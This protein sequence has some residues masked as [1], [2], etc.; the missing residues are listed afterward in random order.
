[1]MIEPIDHGER[2]RDERRARPC[3]RTVI[4]ARCGS[5][6]AR[7]PWLIGGVSAVTVRLLV[8]GP[9]RRP[10]SCVELRRLRR[11][12]C[13]S[14]ASSAVGLAG[15]EL[16]HDPALVHDEDAVGRARG[17]PRVRGS[18][19]G[20]PCRASRSARICAVHELDRADVEPARR[21][22]GDEQLRIAPD[23]ARDDDLLLVAA[24]EVAGEHA[25]S[26]RADVV[27]G[28]ALARRSSPIAARV[29][30]AALRVRR[31]RGGRR[32]RGSRPGRTRRT[33][34]RR[35]R[36]SGMCETPASIVSRARRRA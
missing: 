15:R 3:A 28:D 10:R 7:R 1:M 33:S 5:T 34:P 30:D 29:H 32:A 2:D 11:R 9:G 14:R 22:R 23:L 6:G 36:S 18:R 8:L 12:S 19:A 35:W 26:G 31:A 24:G 16:R 25:R 4:H 21:L 13:S 27:V 17:P 20:P